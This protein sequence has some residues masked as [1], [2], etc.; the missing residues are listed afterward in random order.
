MGNNI[1]IIYANKSKNIVKFS[2]DRVG[3]EKVAK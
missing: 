3:S 1:K 2:A